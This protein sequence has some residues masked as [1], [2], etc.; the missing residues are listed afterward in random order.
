VKER[1]IIKEVDW[2]SWEDPF[3]FEK[4]EKDYKKEREGSEEER[5]KR[6]RYVLPAIE[7]ILKLSN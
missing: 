6:L 1:L 2:L 3:I 7:M 4:N 5:Q